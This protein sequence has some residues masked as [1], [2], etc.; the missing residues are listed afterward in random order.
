MRQWF[1]VYKRTV[2]SDGRFS[3]NETFCNAV[4]YSICYEEGHFDIRSGAHGQA[5]LNGPDGKV[6]W[7]VIIGEGNTDEIQHYYAQAFRAAREMYLAPALYNMNTPPQSFWYDFKI[8]VYDSHDDNALG[9]FAAW[10]Y[11]FTWPQVRVYAKEN[12]MNRINYCPDE[13]FLSTTYHELGHGIHW[14]LPG[15]FLSV[16]KNVVE[17]WGRVVQWFCTND[18]YRRKGLIMNHLGGLQSL[19]FDDYQMKKGYTPIFIDLIDN[20]NQRAV[21]GNNSLPPDNVSGF[22]LN[23]IQNSLSNSCNFSEIRDKLIALNRAPEADIR[24]LFDYYINNVTYD[25]D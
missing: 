8:G 25:Y 14:D 19:K 12:R 11:W 3:M 21:T 7:N 9:D 20:H 1:C 15:R 16:D 13:V 6:T 24:T 10:R 2:G 17:S 22:T 18:D 23:E 5:K 4:C